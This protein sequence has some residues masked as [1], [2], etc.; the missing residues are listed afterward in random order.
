MTVVER[1][2]RRS[3]LTIRVEYESE[4]GTQLVGGEGT[5]GNQGSARETFSV[6]LAVL[7][8]QSDVTAAAISGWIRE[9]KRR[10]VPLATISDWFKPSPRVPRNDE[11]FLLVI[12]CLYSAGNLPWNQQALNRWKRLR[13]AASNEARPRQPDENDDRTTA[14]EGAPR[15][16]VLAAGLIQQPS[17]QVAPDQG[18]DSEQSTEPPGAKYLDKNMFAK[19]T[20]GAWVAEI[21][22]DRLT[23]A[24]E[25]LEKIL[26][27]VV[28]EL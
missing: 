19:L 26:S 28:E 20:A 24:P 12:E 1:A 25:Q 5:S 18:A 14:E 22:G 6:E 13:T 23:I 27:S 10:T 3:F 16:A 7:R 8:K 11:Q 17:D 9:R 4:K 2:C 21:H 15:G